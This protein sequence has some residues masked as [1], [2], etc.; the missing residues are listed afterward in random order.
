MLNFMIYHGNQEA[1]LVQPHGDNWLQTGRIPLTLLEPYLG[2]GLTVYF[3]NY[4][5]TPRL[6]KYLFDNQTKVV[7]TIRANRHNMVPNIAE[8]VL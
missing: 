2:N 3:D 6:V 8:K 7:G 5:T 4:Y 1:A